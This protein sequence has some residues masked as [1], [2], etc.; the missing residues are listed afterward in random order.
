MSALRSQVVPTKA[1]GA[2]KPTKTVVKA[3]PA[4]GFELIDA[5]TDNKAILSFEP[6]SD[7]AVISEL[8]VLKAQANWA[9]SIKT[10]S[11]IYLA[12]GDYV[13]AAGSAAGELYGYGH[14]NVLFK[15]TKAAEYPFRP[16][17]ESAMSYFVG[18]SA[19]CDEAVCVETDNKGAH[20]LC[21]RFSSAQHTR[22]IDRK[23]FKLRELT[24]RRRISDS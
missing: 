18:G 6:F 24:A 19:E 20:D 4:G 23:L 7:G 17:A 21:H 1:V 11:K 15:P 14:S 9:N 10:I 22:H 13:G 5:P 8:D 16:T 12:G 3:V 2:A